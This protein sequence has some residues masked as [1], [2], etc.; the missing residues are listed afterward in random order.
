MTD[1]IDAPH[2]DKILVVDDTTANLQIL[3]NLLERE[4]Y[5]VFPASDGELALEFVRFTLPDLILLDIRMPGMDGFEVC[6][7]LKASERTCAIPVIFISVLENEHEKVKAF[8]EGAV[9]YITKPFQPDEVLARI[10]THLQLR[11]LTEHLE[12]TVAARTSQL[13]AANEALHKSEERLRLTLEATHV[14]TWEWDVQ[15]DQWSASPVYYTILGYEPQNVGNRSEWLQRVHPD[16]IDQVKAKIK[17]VLAQDSRQFPSGTY[18]YEARLRHAGGGYRW[19]YAKGFVVERDPQGKVMRMRGIRMDI[20]E[21]K[22]AEQELALVSFALNNVHEA[23]FL[24]DENGRFQFVNEESCRVSGY[25]RAEL[26]GMSVPD[27]DPD[28]PA[29]IW[30][31][32]WEDLKARQSMVFER[33][34]KAKDGRTF[35]VE[36][37]ASFID[38]GGKTYNLALV[39]DITERKQAEVT[40]HQL[41]RE[42]SAISNCNQVLMRA[43]DEQSLLQAICQ[44]VCDKAGYRMAWVGYIQNDEAKTVRPV[45][46]A[47][48]VDG[49]LETARIVWSDTE[50]GWGPTGTTI[51]TGA[52]VCCQDF[53]TDPRVA[54]WRVE[55]L[56]RGYR[57][58]ISL[59]LKDENGAVFGALTIYSS[60]PNAFTNDEFR[61]LSELGAD[62]AFGITVLRGRIERRR[63]E[64]EIR[65]LNRDLDQRVKERTG[66]LETAVKELESFSYSVSHDLRTP[67]RSINGFSRALLEDYAPKLDDEARDFLNRVCAAAERMASLID[68]ILRLSQISRADVQ[69]LDVNLSRIVEEVARELKAAEPSRAVEFDIQPDCKVKGDIPLLKIAMENILGN[70]WKYT[71]K[72]EHARIEFG[73]LQTAEGKTLFVRDNGC[74]FDMRY[75]GKLFGAFKRLH[76]SSEFPGTG[77]GLAIVQRVIRKHGGT[78]R[79]EGKLNQGATLYFTLPDGT[80]A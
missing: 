59:P 79:I 33:Q 60:L 72:K 78:L 49:Y 45:A 11:Q 22:E 21:R 6:R 2:L 32:H 61:L 77:I 28:F 31:S 56:R 4:G 43:T 9:D 25:T 20:N 37:S 50:R 63:A 7:R 67:L 3:V 80:E 23:A 68:D 75:A 16:D 13:Q 35:P 8:H 46:W 27:L 47:G 14:A 38:Y 41:N 36:I 29:A 40:L 30:H 70:A 58:T 44:I 69:L 34:H 52:S 66:Q 55:A 73:T 26:L 48:A 24:I 17:A 1:A 65:K 51:R 19:Q 10:R 71:S 76:D 64:E 18:E 62:L 74:G 57:S 53:E 12:K 54:P 42:L 5:A 39:R 15:T